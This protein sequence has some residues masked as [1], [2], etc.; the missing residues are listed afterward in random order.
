[1]LRLLARSRRRSGHGDF[2]PEIRR[3]NFRVPPAGLHAGTSSADAV[4]AQRT[5][6]AAFDGGWRVMVVHEAE[7]KFTSKF[8]EIAVAISAARCR[9]EIARA[10]LGPSTRFSL[11]A[12]TMPRRVAGCWCACRSLPQYKGSADFALPVSLFTGSTHRRFAISSSSTTPTAPDS[13]TS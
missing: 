3:L 5:R 2:E 12:V 8:R 9:S 6:S 1:V 13:E 11:P 10:P 4:C 7:R